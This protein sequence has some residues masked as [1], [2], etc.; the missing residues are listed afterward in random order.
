VLLAAADTYVIVVALPDIMVGVGIDGNELQRA[1]PLVST[2]LLGY[3]VI[4]PLAGR[5]SDIAGRLPCLIGALLVFSAGSLFTASAHG[6]DLAITGRFLQGAGGGALV[7]VTLAVVADWW[8][9]GR[10]AV[11]LGIV[12][13]VQ[14]LGSVLGPL[15]GAG[16]LA[17]AGWR[18]I[19]WTNLGI[20][21]VLVIGT[22]AV[23]RKVTATEAATSSAG[24][25]DIVSAILIAGALLSG[26]LAIVKPPWLENSVTWG[27]LLVPALDD[28][29]WTSP[30]AIGSI[31]LLIGFI[32]RQF[33]AGR[34]LVTLRRILHVIDPLGA[35]LLAA[36]LVAIVLAFAVAD[37]AVESMAPAGPWLL[38][39]SAAAFAGFGWRER[40]AR[41]PLIPRGTFRA[42]P[43]WGSLVVNLFA[44]AALVAIV[45][46]IPIFARTVIHHSDQLDAAIV[47]L[48][49]LVALPV[50]ALVGGWLTRRFAPAIICAA[51][52]GIAAGSLWVMSIWGVDSLDGLA[53]DVVLV[54]AGLGLGITIAP[55]NA[56]LLAAIDRSTHG[57][58]SAM[59]VLARMMGMLAGLSALTA[60]GLRR[61][62][63]VQATIE[64][65]L[66][67]CPDSPT[68]CPP[69]DDALRTAVVEQLQTT[70][71]GGAVCAALAAATAVLLLHRQPLRENAPPPPATT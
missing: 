52:M 69:Y 59:L 49:F 67:T 34:P 2:F 6:L 46:D 22:A 11:P 35:L 13:A 23:R 40:H 31:A 48:R 12:G 62:Y 26:C 63:D 68:D 8:P 15:L 16:I 56:S 47:L 19:F 9:P 60:L 61:F 41:V 1:V 51:G 71:A 27:G 10:R 24:R 42:R 39:G 25:P 30:L 43:A 14:E 57:I 3:L 7:P 66:V 38:L 20:G 54:A 64:S 5:V 32:A 65:P 45:V 4:L 21:L 44:G 37:P 29:R 17:I 55:T 50:G 36:A 70:F 18:T 53:D 33:I 28:N 58:A